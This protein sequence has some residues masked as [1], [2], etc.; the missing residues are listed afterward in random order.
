VLEEVEVYYDG[1]GEHWLWGTLVSTTAI[2][3]RPQMVFEYSDEARHRGL[4]L[5][6]FM[7]AL[8]G[9]KLRR[10]FPSCQQTL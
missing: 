1:G 4:E 5:S 2:N 10:G 7:L 6:S 8:A 3:V 9:D